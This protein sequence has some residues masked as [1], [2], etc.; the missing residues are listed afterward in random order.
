MAIPVYS[1]TIPEYKVKVFKKVSKIP[2]S[3]KMQIPKKYE[4]NKPDFEL[5]SSKIIKCLRKHFMGRRIAFRLL[6]SMEHPEKSVA[7]LVKI[8]KKL[9][10]D[11]HDLSRIGDRYENIGNLNIDFFALD[12]EVGKKEEEECVKWALNSFYAWPIFDRGYPVRV[13]MGIVYD[14]TQLKVVEHRY[15]G[16]EHEVKRDGFVFKYPDRKPEAVL[17]IVKIL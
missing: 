1:I 2:Y 9:G 6:G 16:R 11:K 8:I 3:A 14:L 13:D 12:F 7:D 10:H 5:I 4:E 15:T 17:G